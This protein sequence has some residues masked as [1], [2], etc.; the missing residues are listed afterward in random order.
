MEERERGGVGG[1]G[2]VRK[3]K[4]F[5]R[6]QTRLKNQQQHNYKEYI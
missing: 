2:I 1:G 5:D 6:H 4:G 3:G